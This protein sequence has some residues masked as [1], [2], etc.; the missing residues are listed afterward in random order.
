MDRRNAAGAGR[1]TPA[2][3]NDAE[4]HEWITPTE[5]ARR[6]VAEGLRP[7]MTRQRIA[8]LADSDPQWPCPRSSW[9]PLGRYQT[10]P[11]EPV[12]AYFTA[13]EATKGGTPDHRPAPGTQPVTVLLA[14][15]RG[16]ARFRSPE[17]PQLTGTTSFLG[18]NQYSAEVDASEGEA[19]A[20][21]RAP[22]RETAIRRLAAQLG[23]HVTS[24]T[25]E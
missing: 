4:A 10:L 1:R 17:A 11:W 2:P 20:V 6:V 14:A 24:I 8:Q 21:V 3:A 12:R 18:K 5:A 9:R 19:P 25:V 15:S 22:R 23:L 16:H 7:S 13:R